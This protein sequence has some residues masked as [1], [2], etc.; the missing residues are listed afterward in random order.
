MAVFERNVFCMGRDSRGESKAE[1]ENP[2][3]GRKEEGGLVGGHLFDLRSASS[4]SP[5]YV[6]W[7][8]S[9]QTS[10]G[11][12]DGSLSSLPRLDESFFASFFRDENTFINISQGNEGGTK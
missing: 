4:C 11:L 1:D 9:Y 3:L 8:S 10:P 6:E 2:K 5:V 12:S 7:G